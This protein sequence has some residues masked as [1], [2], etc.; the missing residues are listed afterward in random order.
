MVE[1]TRYIYSQ[2]P[3]TVGK[4][5]HLLDLLVPKALFPFVGRYKDYPPRTPCSNLH[6]GTEA[7]ALRHSLSRFAASCEWLFRDSRRVIYGESNALNAR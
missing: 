3:F 1:A 7:G 6:R 2:E 4:C 5:R